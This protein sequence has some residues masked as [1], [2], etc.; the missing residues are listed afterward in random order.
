MWQNR[1][2]ILRC[3]VIYQRMK[4]ENITHY[5][6]ADELGKTHE[7]IKGILYGSKYPQK[8]V[9]VDKL[10][11]YLNLTPD[12]VVAYIANDEGEKIEGLTFAEMLKAEI[13]G[14][15]LPTED[16]YYNDDKKLK[17]QHEKL[18]YNFFLALAFADV[19]M[20]FS[21]VI[22]HE[23]R[24]YVNVIISRYNYKR[25][26]FDKMEC[27]LLKNKMRNIKGFTDEE[28]TYYYNKLASMQDILFDKIDENRRLYESDGF[29]LDD[30]D[31]NFNDFQ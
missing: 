12:D 10:C 27:L 11:G 4:E 1:H 24:E 29:N 31:K 25:D 28:A 3:D 23:G 16:D 2:I 8:A 18:T 5:E 14:I 21:N 19:Y 9:T 6:L 7:F 17:K 15:S 13:L 30:L 22:E 20:H 26:D